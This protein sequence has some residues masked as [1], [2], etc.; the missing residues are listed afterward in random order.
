MIRLVSLMSL[1]LLSACASGGREYSLEDLDGARWSEEG[2]PTADFAISGN[3]IWLDLDAEYRPCRIEDGN[4]L[5]YEPLPGMGE[6]RRRIVSLGEDVLVLESVGEAVA[7]Q[8]TYRRR[9]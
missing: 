1:L 3:E 5:V 8:R 9:E 7:E 4:T 2:A 6:I